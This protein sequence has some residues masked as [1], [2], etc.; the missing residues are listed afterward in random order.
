[1]Q[2]KKSYAIRFAR[3]YVTEYIHY[4]HST[5]II[6]TVLISLHVKNK[7]KIAIHYQSN[8]YTVKAAYTKTS[9]NPTEKLIVK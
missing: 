8:I 9:T 1:M 3:G 6:Y 5:D 4:D 2:L 7:Q